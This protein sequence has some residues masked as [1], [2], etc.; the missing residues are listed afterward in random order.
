[1]SGPEIAPRLDRIEASDRATLTIVLIP[2]EASV[3]G[4]SLK[5]S[6]MADDYERL[7]DKIELS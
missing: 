1:V 5:E 4:P 3:E 6:R 2:P 7:A